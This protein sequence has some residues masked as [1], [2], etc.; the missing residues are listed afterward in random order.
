MST[1]LVPTMTTIDSTSGGHDTKT[2]MQYLDPESTLMRR[3]LTPGSA[4]NTAKFVWT[5]V[6][7]RDA[8]PMRKDFS[9]ERKGFTLV[10][11][12]SKVSDWDDTEQ[13]SGIYS[14][15]IEQLITSMTGADKV[16]VFEPT[17]R[18]AITNSQYQPFGSEVHVDYTRQ[19]AENL[20]SSFLAK[21]N[22]Q[23]TDY[24]RYQC[25]NVWRV[26]SESPQDYP[27]GMCDATSVLSGDF[28]EMK[29][30]RVDTLPTGLD[31]LPPQEP[32]PDTPAADMF[33]HRTQHS[34]WFFSDMGVDEALVFK[35][36]DSDQSAKAPRCP[37]T[38]FQD[39]VREGTKPRASIE[40]RT[41]ACFK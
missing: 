39:R 36:Y 10:D 8:R 29:R 1:I 27:L 32:P 37:H 28:R 15:E 23:M 18:R 20:I 38:A 7:V 6:N 22:K 17:L 13:Q 30:I 25:I 34:W 11:H 2:K 12:A 35:L 3:Y 41:I 9:L 5:D 40:I 14:R 24:S 19:T 33:E 31:D 4:F 21:D 26:L 16:Y